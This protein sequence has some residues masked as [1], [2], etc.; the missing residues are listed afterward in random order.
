MWMDS[1]QWGIRLDLEPLW[2]FGLKQHLATMYSTKTKAHAITKQITTMKCISHVVHI[3][4]QLEQTRDCEQE[5]W[6][7]WMNWTRYNWI[8]MK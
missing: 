6:C 1:R 4:D 3:K 7:Y 8:E 2:N 5:T